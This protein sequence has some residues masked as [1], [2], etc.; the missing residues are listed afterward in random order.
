MKRAVLYARVSTSHHGQ[1][2]ENQLV[3]LREVCH[4]QGWTI[5]Q[6]LSDEVS[7]SK[8]REDRAGFDTL[9]KGTAVYEAL[10]SSGNA[11]KAMAAFNLGTPVLLSILGDMMYRRL[12]YNEQGELV[13]NARDVSMVNWLQQMLQQSLAA[14][15]IN[16]PT[17]PAP[18]VAEAPPPVS[19][20]A[21]GEPATNGQVTGRDDASAVAAAA[22]ESSRFDAVE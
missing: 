13:G 2:T 1:T 5:V 21:A 9:L 18:A 19:A 3:V 7:G 4:H 20:P 15:G 8:G 12:R 10:T 11:E 17:P 16:I 14:Q 22:A 6:E